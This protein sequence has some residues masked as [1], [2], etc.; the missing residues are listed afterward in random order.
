MLRLTKFINKT[1]SVRLSLMVVSSM[2]V[3]LAG[4]LVVMLYYSRKAVKEEALQKTSQALEGTMQR[5]DNILLSV[6]QASG[7]I[8][9]NMLSHFNEPDLLN[10]YCYK[11]VEVSPYVRRAFIAFRPNYYQG[12]E[13]YLVSVERNTDGSIVLTEAGDH[14]SSSIPKDYTTSEWYTQPMNTLKPEWLIFGKTKDE[15]P[16]N[17][18]EPLITFCLPFSQRDSLPIGVMALQLSLTELSHL[19]QSNN[20][21]EKSFFSLIASDGTVISHPDSSKLLRKPRIEKIKAENPSMMEA[22]NAMIQGESGYRKFERRGKNY[23]VFY[24]P[25]IRTVVQGRSMEHLGWSAGIIYPES[26]IKGDYWRLIYFVLFISVGGLLVLF[27]LSRAIIHRQL[28]PLRLLTHSAQQIAEGNYDVEVPE[29]HHHDEIGRLQNDFQQM[30]QSLSA[31][32][33]ELEQLTATLDQRGKELRAAYDWARKANRMKTAFLHHMT[34]QMV[35]PSQAIFNAVFALCEPGRDMKTK[36]VDE[37]AEDIHVQG[38]AIT[39]LL[40]NL[41]NVSEEETGKEVEKHD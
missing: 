24:K 37:L 31:H 7:N 4:S 3:L 30:Q 33:N 11:L 36:Q 23:L 14:D 26:N 6:E 19:I 40:N 39:E 18:E 34:N 13:L 25:F 17:S 29:S 1:L 10:T 2:A 5:I 21:I 38:K 9:F 41:L 28:L 15:D 32:V 35:K 20:P 12:H 16:D 8:Y 27:V 22:M